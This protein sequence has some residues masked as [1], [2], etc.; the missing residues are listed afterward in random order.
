MG[1]YT[2]IERRREQG[3]CFKCDERY[4]PEHRCKKKQLQVLI[5]SE[6]GNIEEKP[7]DTEVREEEV[8]AGNVNEE[9]L[10]GQPSQLMSL[11][12][13]ALA[14]FNG[15]RTIK[16]EGEIKNHNVLVLIV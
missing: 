2:E 10:E 7:P 6:E 12:L 11:S 4:R 16:L 14:G 8:P 13:N 15:G 3:L 5:L 1:C 9:L